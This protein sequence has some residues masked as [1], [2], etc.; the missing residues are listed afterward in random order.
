MKVAKGLVGLLILYKNVCQVLCK[1]GSSV[2]SG[3][4]WS[5]KNDGKS[6]I[7]DTLNSSYSDIENLNS[8]VSPLLFDLTE[9]SDY[10]R[11]Y[12]LNL[13]NKECR[14]NLDDNVACGSSACNVLVTDEQDVPEVWSSKSLGKLEGFMPELSR[15][16]VETDRSVMEH[17]DKI[18]QSCLLE[19]LDDEA[20]QY[21]YVDNELD[22]GCVYVSLL[23]NPERFTGYSGPHST[24]IWEMIYNQCLPDSSAPTIDFPALFMQ[25]PLAPP[26]KP[27]EQL[28]KERMDAWTLEQRVFYRVLSGMHSSIS[29]HLCHGYLNQRNGVWGPNL[30]CFQEKVLNYPERLENLYFAYALMQRAIDKL[31]GH[32]DSLTFCHDSVLQDSEVR[33]K[34]AGLVSLIHN[35][36]KMFDETM[37]FAGDPSISTAL[38]EDFREHFKTVSALMDCVGCE[39]C[40]LW[41]KIQTNGFGTALKI[42]FEVSNIEDEVTNFDSRSFSLR[43]RRSEIVALIN[44]FDRL[45]RSINFVDDF[46]QIYSEQHKP[47]SFKRRVLR[48]IKQLLFSV[49][50][51]ALHPF[52]QKTSSILVDLYFDFKAEWDNVMLG[53]RY[54]FASY[55]RFPRLFKFV[56]F[57]Q[58]SPFLNWT[59]HHLQRYIPKNWFPEVASV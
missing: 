53:F 45:S 22:S 6:I 11:F 4:P 50:P 17:V 16:I 5:I 7:H 58:E 9:K 15:Q 27:Q 47:A 18:S 37:L 41:G 31:Y 55:L 54:V 52:L 51:V 44:T 24:R 35:S 3:S 56:L 33:Q 25:G 26:P 12:R 14:Y 36:P 23:E 34:I 13:F 10:M 38:K 28:L 57:S 46:K 43:L 1:S 30:Q 42:L 21:C 40:R 48:R 8:R 20:H 59:S 32:L 2:K 49:T 29:T 39:R 19:R